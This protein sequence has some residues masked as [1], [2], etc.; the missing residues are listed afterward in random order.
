MRNQQSGGDIFSQGMIITL[1]TEEHR[2]YI[3]SELG[4]TLGLLK[5]PL[6]NKKVSYHLAIGKIFH[7]FIP[8]KELNIIFMQFFY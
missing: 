5:F 2:M 6:K 4:R 8:S 7:L 3:L 1:S